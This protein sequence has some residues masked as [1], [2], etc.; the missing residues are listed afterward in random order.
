MLVIVMGDHRPLPSG[1]S[2]ASLASRARRP[3]Q[4]HTQTHPQQL[5]HG[6]WIGAPRVGILP[7]PL[8]IGK[9]VK[10]CKFSVLQFPIC[11]VEILSVYFFR[12]SLGQNDSM[13]GDA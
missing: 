3:G 9:L 1:G 5:K 12:L 4:M 10:S 11:N 6:L 7:L 8:S 2:K 13:Q